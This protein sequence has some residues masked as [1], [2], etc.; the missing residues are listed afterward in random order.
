MHSCRDED[1]GLVAPELHYFLVAEGGSFGNFIALLSLMRR[2]D[3]KIY[4][5]P[6]IT[7]VEEV[8]PKED[9]FIVVVL[10][11]QSQYIRPALLVTIGVGKR[12]LDTGY[13]F[14]KHKVKLKH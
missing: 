10:L 9:L 8:V 12:E 7:L 5:S 13:K 1:D 11:I 4:G 6:L 2:Y 3:D 14:V